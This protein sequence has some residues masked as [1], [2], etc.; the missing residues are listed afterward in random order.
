MLYLVSYPRIPIK[1]K[2]G[3]SLK[4]PEEKTDNLQ[5]M[6]SRVKTKLRQMLRTIDSMNNRC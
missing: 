4:L 3:T 2:G 1:Y 6:D 5:R